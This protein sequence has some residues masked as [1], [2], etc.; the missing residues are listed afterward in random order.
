M[1][2][3]ASLDRRTLL[4]NIAVSAAAGWVAGKM[5]GGPARSDGTERAESAYQ[6]VMRTGVLR[7]GYFI[8]PPLT[9]KDPNTGKLSGI[10]VDLTEALARDL[11]LKLEWVEEVNASTMIEGLNTGRYDALCA[12][13]WN[14]ASRARHM[15]HSTPYLYTPIGAY[16]RA[17]EHRFDAGWEKANDPSVTIAGIDGDGAFLLASKAFPKGKITLL[18]QFSSHAE[19]LLNV[20][21]GKADITF[22][23]LPIFHGYEAH[24]P[25]RLRNVAAARPFNVMGNSFAFKKG[26]L[27]M[28]SMMDMAIMTY[29]NSGEL[30]RIIDR[31]EE[32]RGD[33]YRVQRPYRAA[34]A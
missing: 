15:E 11:N 27:G 20:E 25:G 31:Y 24:N 18:P 8:E 23:I 1:T 14:I 2:Q 9:M 26:E 4:K 28:K 6:R 19:L 17:G 21:A 33:F 29:L 7:A 13:I 30:D 16:V 10:V 5:A 3:F 12:S 34:N 32:H 22:A